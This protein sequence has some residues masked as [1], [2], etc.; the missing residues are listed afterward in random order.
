MRDA[1]IPLALVNVVKNKIYGDSLEAL[2]MKIRL[3]AEQV[4]S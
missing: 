1:Y 2:P 4:A 3:A